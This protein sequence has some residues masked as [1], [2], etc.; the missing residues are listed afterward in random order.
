MRGNLLYNSVTVIDHDC[1][2]LNVYLWIELS[3][4][5]AKTS[6]INLKRGHVLTTC[7]LGKMLSRSSFTGVCIMIWTELRLTSFIFFSLNSPLRLPVGLIAK[8]MLSPNDLQPDTVCY[9]L[10]TL[11]GFNESQQFSAAKAYFKSITQHNRW[12]FSSDLRLSN[13]IKGLNL[14]KQK[15]GLHWDIPVFLIE[16]I[17]INNKS[18]LDMI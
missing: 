8:I 17:P 6:I 3:V 12:P 11:P 15:S 4:N 16:I 14:N 7:L 1:G 9:Y 18:T 10:K 2:I 5:A 13:V